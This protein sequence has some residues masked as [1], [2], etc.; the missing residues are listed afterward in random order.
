MP[1]RVRIIRGGKPEEPKPVEKPVN[2]E[3]SEPISVE[4]TISP[5]KQS[6]SPEKPQPASVNSTPR[7]AD[8]WRNMSPQ[9]LTKTAQRSLNRC[10][11]I[12]GM[13]I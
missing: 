9:I 7:K 12:I 13:R 4:K 1:V 5:Q 2:R 3:Q 10:N 8:K 11:P 6:I